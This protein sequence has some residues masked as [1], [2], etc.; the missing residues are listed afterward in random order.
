LTARH[1]TSGS[2][3]GSKSV[4]LDPRPEST[5]PGQ[6]QRPGTLARKN[7]APHGKEAEERKAKET[8]HCV[9]TPRLALTVRWLAFIF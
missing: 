5:N 8:G 6:G 2:T 7:P 4:R 3:A 9:T 1:S